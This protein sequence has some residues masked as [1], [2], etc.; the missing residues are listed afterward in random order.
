MNNNLALAIA[1]AV[2]FAIGIVVT[3]YKIVMNES[4]TLNGFFRKLG[5]KSFVQDNTLAKT[6]YG[7]L[8]TFIFAIVLM[9]VLPFP[10]ATIGLVIAVVSILLC[11]LGLRFA[12]DPEQ[13][14]ALTSGGQIMERDVKRDGKDEKETIVATGWFMIP[15]WPPYLIGT[16]DVDLS[17]KDWI[18][19]AKVYSVEMP[20]PDSRPSDKKRQ[21]PLQG[22]LNMTVAVNRRYVKDFF[23]AS[24]GGDTNNI[25]P[26][27]D[28][29]AVNKIKDIIVSYQHPDG[30]IGL[31]AIE[32]SQKS[33]LISDELE[34][35]L[36]GY[37]T[38]DGTKIEGVFSQKR[39]GL[40]LIKVQFEAPM[41]EEIEEAMIKAGSIEFENDARLSEMAA[42]VKGAGIYAAFGVKDP[43]AAL[44]NARQD[45]LIRDGAV[46][47][48][49]VTTGFA[50][51]STRGPRERGAST[52]VLTGTNVNMGPK[53]SNRKKGEN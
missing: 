33:K 45:R 42:D 41:P 35:H 4:D 29:I 43:E 30:R 25:K 39:F 34:K 52:I 48:L 15:A 6:F 5:M 53:Q 27:I 11:L 28:D 13:G 36:N 10:L 3:V 50:S 44:N 16:R 51:S 18:F 46:Q 19:D 40:D 20:K 14:K 24:N 17:M 2:L 32:V 7:T 47:Q 1:L 23:V 9:F 8:L 38:P 21:L 22:K 26:M 37:T 12:K 49:Q 31:T